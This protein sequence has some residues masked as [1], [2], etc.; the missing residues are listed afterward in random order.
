[1]RTMVRKL[2]VTESVWAIFASGQRP[3]PFFLT[4]ISKTWPV[5]L[6]ICSVRVDRSRR[7]KAKIEL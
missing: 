6:Q 7:S 3:A 5:A 2:P 4:R 1:M